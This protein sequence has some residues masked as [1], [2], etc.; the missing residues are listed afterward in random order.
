[1]TVASLVE[2]IIN[3]KGYVVIPDLLSTAEAELAR[4]GLQQEVVD[5]ATPKLKQLLGYEF[6]SA[7]FKDIQKLRTQR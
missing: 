7:L 2:E 5:R 3:G 6:K 1:M 4:S